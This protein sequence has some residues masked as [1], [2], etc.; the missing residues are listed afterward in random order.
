MKSIMISFMLSAP[1]IA[2][3]QTNTVLTWDECIA[4]T[5]SNNPDMISARSAVR[6]SEYSVIS[7]NSAFLPDISASAGL[8]FGQSENGDDWNDSKSSSGSLSLSQDLFSG[9]GNLASKRKAVA[10]L[11]VVNEQYRQTLSDVEL[12]TRLAFVEVL[13]AQDLIE[14][15]EKIAERRSDNVR[16]IQLRFDGGRENAGSLARSK[17][18]LAQAE[19]EVREA[20]RSLAYALRNLS[21][22]IGKSESMDGV[23]GNLQAVAPAD[24]LELELLMA[25]TP[26]YVIA[27]VQVEAANDGVVVARSSLFP[28]IRFSAS[29]GIGSGNYE[30]YNGNWSM[31]LNASVPIYTGRRTQSEV[32]A[33]KE[34]VIQSEMGLLDT[35][36]TLLASLQQQRNSYVNAVESESIQKQLYDAET[37]RAEISAAKYKQGLLDYEDWD[38]IEN[39]LISQ[40][41]SYLQARRSSEMQQAYWRNALGLSIWSAEQGE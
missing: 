25:Q 17:A 35:A 37:L 26:E 40:G 41:K 6:E 22:A 1:V 9:G 20:K 8:S 39:A 36:N 27:S 14:L 11:Q 2:M 12:R 16:L 28:T 32:A 34:R 30:D 29:A 18:Q 5:K 7:A 4:Q 21:A 33:A 15:T 23:S 3:A 13:Y 19:F 24:G 10:Q 31:G 38:T